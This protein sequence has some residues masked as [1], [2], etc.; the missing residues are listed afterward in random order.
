MRPT[1]RRLVFSSVAA[2]ALI[3]GAWRQ[4]AAQQAAAQQA[5]AQQAAAQQAAI[6]TPESVLGF[7]VGADFKLATYDE[8]QRYF[9]ALAA[10]SNQIR[11]ID[12]G[13]TSNG[14]PWTLAVISSAANLAKLDRYREIAQRLAHPEGL[15]DAAARALA[16]EG[17]AFVDI[18]GGLHASEIAGSQH[19]IQLAYDL[20]S[21]AGEPQTRAILDNT[22]LFLWPSLNPTGRISW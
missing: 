9:Q 20:L 19:T 13:K 14:H 6:P 11:L 12:V 16:Q 3:L 2:A 1:N 10:A 17:R 7:P 5:A 8:S 18:S 4:A 21:K 22:V 15:T